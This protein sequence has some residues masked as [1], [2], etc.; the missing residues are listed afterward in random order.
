MA[1]PK[2]SKRQMTSA[3]FAAVRPFLNISDERIEAAYAQAHWGSLWLGR[4]VGAR[5]SSLF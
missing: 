2:K 4:T 5:C 1:V 3:E